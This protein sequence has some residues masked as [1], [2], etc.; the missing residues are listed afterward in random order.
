MYVSVG[1]RLKSGKV[2]VNLF[3]NTLSLARIPPTGSF[4]IIIGPE[5]ELLAAWTFCSFRFLPVC[6]HKLNG[7]WCS[8]PSR[9][10]SGAPTLL[11]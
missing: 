9:L 1:S 3:P 7:G 2:P 4:S 6:G 5:N 11:L 10:K 8:N